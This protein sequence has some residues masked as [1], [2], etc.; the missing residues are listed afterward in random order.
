VPHVQSSTGR[1]PAPTYLSSDHDPVYRFHQWQADLQILDVKAIHDGAL[2]AADP[3][4][5]NIPTVCESPR[6][7]AYRRP[8]RVPMMLAPI[9]IGDATVS[10]G[11]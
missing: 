11:Q 10:R 4:F 5:A 6:K 9:A 7:R 8:S 2:R 3:G 1:Q